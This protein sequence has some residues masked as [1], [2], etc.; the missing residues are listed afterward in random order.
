MSTGTR[1][2][3]TEKDQLQKFAK[4]RM[5]KATHTP[6]SYMKKMP[7]IHMA[8]SNSLGAHFP[9]HHL[10]AYQKHQFNGD[11]WHGTIKF[12]RRVFPDASTRKRTITRPFK[13]MMAQ[14][15]TALQWRTTKH[16]GKEKTPR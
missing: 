9:S 6:P 2:R 5:Q 1:E 3:K 7:T 4:M 13:I 12:L 11:H 15:R 16:I 8:T 14:Q 10:T